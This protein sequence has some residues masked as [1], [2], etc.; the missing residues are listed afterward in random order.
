MISDDVRPAKPTALP[1]RDASIPEALK[2]E[3]RWCVWRYS[4]RDGRWTK[5][6]H[7]PNGH[8]AKSND[9]ATWCSFTRA[10]DAYRTRRFDGVEFMLGDGWAGADLDDCVHE[11]LIHP[12]ARRLTEWLGAYSELSPS[13]T[14]VKVVCRANR[15]GLEVNFETRA[16]TPW[17]APRPFTITGHGAGDPTV[18][19]SAVF[20]T[21]LPPLPAAQSHTKRGYEEA[22]EL[23]DNDL[24]LQI[25]SS[26]QGEKFLLLWMGDTSAYATHS[27]ADMA[28]V[29]ILAWWC[30]YDLDRVDR[31]FRESG[32]M[33]TKWHTASYRTS[34]LRKTLL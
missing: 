6:P 19:C 18:D 5:I 32:L 16:A 23:D 12:S 27:E 4:W 22:A 17:S 14:G 11:G 30:D 34:T 28:L 31:I 24:L 10:L 2:C 1:V 21:I 25:V 15:V 9:S 33:R 7:Q 26:A 8:F 29:S 3:P 20:A 13:G